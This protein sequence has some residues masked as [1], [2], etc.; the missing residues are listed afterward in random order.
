[1]PAFLCRKSFFRK[2]KTRASFLTGV[3]KGTTGS[4]VAV[5]QAPSSAARGYACC[6]LLIAVR[7]MLVP[8][9][10]NGLIKLMKCDCASAASALSIGLYLECDDQE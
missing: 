9:L 10:K 3:L 4:G 1:M 8:F 6:E 5:C 7:G 2:T